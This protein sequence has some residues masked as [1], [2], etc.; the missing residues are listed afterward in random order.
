MYYR[1]KPILPRSLLVQMRRL[2]RRRVERTDLDLGWPVED[3]YARFLWGTAGHL[4]ERA[5]VSEAPFVH[6]WPHG[7]SL[8]LVLTHD[9]ETAEGQAFVPSLAKLEEELGFR[10]SFNFVAERYP[11]DRGL[12][13]D[14]QARGFEVGI[15][16]LKHDGHLF[17]TR[18]EFERRARLINGHLRAL[19]AVGF[20][21]PLTHRNP[22]WMQSLDVEY[23][24]S[25]FDSDPFEPIPGG[26]MSVWPFVLGRFLELP[27][28]L[29]QDFTLT[30][31][32]GERSPRLWLDKVDFL[33]RY[34]G[35]ALLNTHPDYLRDAKRMCIYRQFLETVRE[36]PRCWHA[37]PK[38]V[39][40]WWRGRAVAD[41]I[42]SLPG[43]VGGIVHREKGGWVTITLAGSPSSK[44]AEPAVAVAPDVAAREA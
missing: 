21:S 42:T 37:L 1:L 41:K 35:M 28:T 19:G 11:L 9:I 33:A 22:A 34:F 24:L 39:A 26:T 29:A 14:L 10:S 31:V 2:H 43:A 15:H 18:H 36:R 23:D 12:I 13:G 16:G 3:R 32:V 27:Y 6:F 38:D 30:E 20:R 40:R 5:G 4:L 17:R 7:S 44:E 8:A 25:F